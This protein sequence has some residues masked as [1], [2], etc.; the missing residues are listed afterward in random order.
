MRNGGVD[1]TGCHPP[2]TAGGYP[3]TSL[4]SWCLEPNALMI[5]DIR[6]RALLEYN[7]VG[8]QMVETRRALPALAALAVP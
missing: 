8:V 6:S 5:L 7:D 1:G 2:L 4:G 3:D